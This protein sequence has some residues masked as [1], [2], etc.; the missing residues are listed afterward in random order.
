[1]KRL[2]YVAMLVLL[3]AGI[4]SG[5]S[6]P[7]VGVYFGVFYSS[8]D[9]HGDWISIGGGVYA[10]HPLHVSVNWMP[11]HHGRWIWTD[12]G[13]YWVSEEPWAWAVY[14]YGRWQYDDYYGWIWIPGCDWAPAWVE[15]RVS[16]SCVGWA[17]L[18]PSAVFEPGFGIRYTHSWVVPAIHWT[19]VDL[20][21]I[22]A[23]DVYRH[24][25]PAGANYHS[26]GSTRRAGSVIL[27]RG[28]ILTGGPGR[29]FV[30]E[31]TG[32]HVRQVETVE[33][34]DRSRSGLR[35]EGQRETLRIF[36]PDVRTRDGEG[37]Q[38]ADRPG[39]MRDYGTGRES[40]RWSNPGTESRDGRGN[41]RVQEG[42]PE[43]ITPPANASPERGLGSIRGEGAVRNDGAVRNERAA[44][45]E[46]VVRND[47]AVRSAGRMSGVRPEAPREVEQSSVP[48]RV[49]GRDDGRGS[50]RRSREDQG[51][52]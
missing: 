11:Y 37:M 47:G 19:F 5:H 39:R 32:R 45:N 49:R 52:R 7:G 20:R 17:P 38:S 29:H 21:Y 3:G 41:G 44:R 40:S 27:E 51:R 18:G 46:S 31:R 28:R 4:V 30:E 33:V 36:R 1:M 10:W 50:E 34:S 23:P 26:L 16:G 12:D 42:R 15:W 6:S 48:D 14:H 24:A 2:L 9:A 25:Y 13:W 43:S 35:V 8:L 22:D